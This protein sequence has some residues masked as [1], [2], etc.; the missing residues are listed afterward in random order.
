MRCI[1]G[2]DW[3][4]GLGGLP[5]PYVVLNAGEGHVQ[6]YISAGSSEVAVGFSVFLYFL[7]L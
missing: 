2:P 1:Q 4:G 7:C 5:T 3:R 6:Y